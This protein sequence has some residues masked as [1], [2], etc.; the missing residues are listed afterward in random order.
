MPDTSKMNESQKYELY[1]DYFKQKGVKLDTR[2][3]Q[4]SILGLRVTTNSK[5]NGNK[6]A[7]DDRMVVLWTDKNG[8][9]RVKEFLTANTEPN[10]RYV[11]NGRAERDV[12]RDGKKELGRIGD[13]AY[14]FYKDSWKYGNALREADNVMPAL[15]DTTGDGN[16]D[17]RDTKSQCQRNSVSSRLTRRRRF[18]EMSDASAR[19][20]H[21]ILEFF[22]R[23][24]PIYISFGNR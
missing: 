12:N 23:R 20:I 8:Q 4:R 21:R 19:K 11:A 2:P 14:E 13:G 5:A 9:K 1:A 18:D 22:R 7:Y 16:Y 10:Y 24:Q 15:Y 3:E 17:N 6:G